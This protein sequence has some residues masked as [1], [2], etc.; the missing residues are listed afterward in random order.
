MERRTNRVREEEREGVREGGN[1]RGKKVER[2]GENTAVIPL[3][4]NLLQISRE[5]PHQRALCHGTCRSRSHHHH[6][7]QGSG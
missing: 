6:G 3:V 7:G 2:E 4:W 1:E 5:P